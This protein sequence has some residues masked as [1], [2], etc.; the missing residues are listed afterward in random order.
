MKLTNEIRDRII[1]SMALSAIEKDKSAL[2]KREHALALKLWKAVYPS[3]ERAAA[4]K[5]AEGWVRM[6]KCLRFNLCGM[7]I[8]LDTAEPVPVKASANGYCHR[9]GDIADEKLAE[10]YRAY[11]RDWE[12]LKKKGQ[13]IQRQGKALLYSVTTFKRLEEAW[14]DGKKFYEKF[15]PV[16]EKGGV[17]A[18]LMNDLNALMGIKAKVAA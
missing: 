5:M 9:L 18:L 3:T 11:Y 4:A 13:D 2:K 15:K 6:D 1:N 14:P 7:D 17:P 8:R 16:S 12:A 10:E